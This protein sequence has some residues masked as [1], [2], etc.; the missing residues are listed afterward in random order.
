MMAAALAEAGMT[1]ITVAVAMTVATLMAGCSQVDDDRLAQLKSG[2]TT[3]AEATVLLGSPDRDE[4]LPD[5]SRMLTYIGAHTLPNAAN[6]LPGL[7]YVW[8]GWTARTDEAGLMF[9]PEGIL[10]F[11]AWSSN[12]TNRIKVVG[13]DNQAPPTISA[14]EKQSPPPSD[15]KGA[16][17]SHD[18]L[19]D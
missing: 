11:Y 8:G 10:R 2:K 12:H 13:K 18:L 7:V 5:G 16:Q 9:S 17:P 3:L 15:G 1:Q 4:T 19:A 14:S 6:A